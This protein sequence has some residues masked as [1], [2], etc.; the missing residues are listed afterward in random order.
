MHVISKAW[1]SQGPHITNQL[2]MM[3]MRVDV[4]LNLPS[5]AAL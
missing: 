3:M 1:F 4:Q 2:L 5:A